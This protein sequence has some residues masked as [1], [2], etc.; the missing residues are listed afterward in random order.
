VECRS[1]EDSVILPGANV[2]CGGDIRHSI[3]WGECASDGDILNT[4]AYN[5]ER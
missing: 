5:D 4:I 1:I 3:L 2:R